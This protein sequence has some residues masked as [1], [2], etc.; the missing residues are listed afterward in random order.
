MKP[1]EKKKDLLENKKTTG[2]D[3]ASEQSRASYSALFNTI[4]HAIY[5]QYADGKF[6]DVNDFACAMYGYAREEFIGRT[7]EF[8]SAP[9]KNDFTAINKKI[10]KAFAGEPQQLVFWGRR[11]NG[12]IFPKEVSLYK[13]TYF[14]KDVLIATGTDILEKK[15]VVQALRES[16][17]KFRS[18][19]E[20]APVVIFT[21]LPSGG[22]FNIITLNPAFEKICGW[23]VTDWVGRSI[24]EIVHPEDLPVAAQNVLNVANGGE[25]PGPFNIRIKSKS[26]EYLIGEFYLR[27][28]IQ[29][30]RITGVMGIA[31]NVTERIRTEETLRESED[32]FRTLFNSANDAIFLHEM[33]PDGIPGRYIKVNDI[34]CQRLGYTRDELLMMSPF[35]IVSK[36]HIL[37]MTQTARIV[38][39]KRHATFETIHKRKNGSEFPVE[40]STHLFELHTKKVALSVARD[41][42]KRKHAEEALIESEERFRSIIESDPLVVFTLAPSGET[43]IITSLNPAFKKNTGWSAG[44][45]VGRPFNEI[46]HPEDLPV[47]TQ[48]V[49][50]VTNGEVP[51]PFNVR[52]KS[53]SGDYLIVEFYLRSH[54]QKGRICGILG[55]AQNVT[56]R[57]RTEEALIESEASYSAL[58]YNNYS[59]S[60]LIDPDTGLIVDAN[61]AACRYYGYSQEHLTS[62]GIYDLNRLQKD[63]VIRNLVRAKNEKEKHFFSTH[64]RADGEKRYVE[65]YSGPITVKGKPLFYS[66]I[67]D[68]T[69]RKQAEQA[70]RE[71]EASYSALFYNNYS[72]SLLIDPDTGLIVDANDAACRYYGYSQEQLIS[73]GIYDLNRLQKDSVV[74]NLVRAKNE[75]EKHFFSTHYRADG[76]KRYVEIYSGPITVKGK[77]LFYSIIHDITDRK[78]AEQALRESETKLNVILQ[79]SPIPTFVIDTGHRVISWNNALEETSGI[80]ANEVIGTNQ[81]WKAFYEMERPCMADMLV[82]GTVEKIPELYKDRYKKSEIIEGAFE[83]TDFF[84]NMGRGGKWLHYIAA[85]IVDTRGKIIGAVETLDDITLLVKAQQSLKESEERYRT[86]I[87]SL[88]DYVIVQREGILLYVNPAAAKNLGYNVPVLIGQP[89]FRFIAPEFY[90]IIRQATKKRM[91]GEDV[92]S[93]E[94]KIIAKDG[95][96]HTVLVNGAYIHYEGLPA[97]LNVL[98]DITALKQA[99]EVIRS[100]NE[101]L[102]KRVAER[103]NALIKANELL[104]SEIAARKNAEEEITRSLNEKVLLLREIHH[105]VKN[106]LQIISSLLNLQSRYITDKKVLESIKDSQ[107]RVRAMA[108]VHE[109]IYRSH[110]IT[111]INLKDY[112]NYLTKQILQFYSTPHYQIRI[113]VTMEDIMADIDTVIPVGLFINEL[114]S[115]SLKHAFPDGRK[116][117][118]SIEC[119]RQAPDTLRFIYH[120]NG[121]GL[122]PGFD[123]KNTESLGLRLVNSLVDQL[124]GTIE[125]GEG[126]GTTFIIVIRQNTDHRTD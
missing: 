122:T 116:G 61:D 118:I 19:V 32:L 97:S 125:M 106:N 37:N 33:L 29:D 98:S 104:V 120:D 115:N 34:A 50:S 10:Q 82:D 109:R 65:I 74:R 94:I 80:K 126:E 44:D 100:A 89:I 7:P 121:T 64:Y 30:G 59:V 60:L 87:D 15:Q 6:I 124:N 14:G 42:T 108:L 58:F 63:S 95:T 113:S 56:E 66:I 88:P 18:I 71:S 123:W 110:N 49:V 4:Q 21:L 73:M 40:I 13:G 20:S 25:Y 107:S 51:A 57:V 23:P 27:P 11:K 69:D 111:E 112:L 12:E 102:E 83:A 70:L 67:H 79:G 28:Y 105:R 68:I 1:A 86:L 76:E 22:T 101:E 48:N 39:Q 55:I 17:Q 96:Y 41:I 92:P 81:H 85:P 54:I 26:G 16:E 93:Y 35:D 90:D 119:T 52:I 62:M 114:V 9:E 38:Q 3:T 46:V 53:K 36:K 47:A 43:F 2:A 84:P 117:I 31:Q 103:T 78:Q 77:P 45:W 8:L 5:I 72:V 75:K 24:G 91:A 99:E